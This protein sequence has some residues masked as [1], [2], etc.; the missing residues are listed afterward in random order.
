MESSDSYLEFAGILQ[1]IER[2]TEAIELIRKM[3]DAKPC[4]NRFE[5]AHFFAIYKAKLD[6]CRRTLSVLSAA[7]IHRLSA[8]VRDLIDQE[9]AKVGQDLEALCQEAL[10]LIDDVLIKNSDSLQGRVFFEKMRGDLFRYLA[11]NSEDAKNAEYADSAEKAYTSAMELSADLPVSD[12]ARLGTILNY[13]VFLYEHRS[14]A[15]RA[16]ELVENAIASVGDEISKLSENS[17]AETLGIIRVMQTN[18]MNWDDP[19]EEEEE[20]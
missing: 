19:E 6:K 16:T 8:L 3:I 2:N 5:R 10:T 15:P 1:N 13:A 7:R 14:N 20:A 17:K 9:K 12:Q 4:L 18:L 11:E